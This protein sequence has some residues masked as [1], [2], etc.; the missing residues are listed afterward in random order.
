MYLTEEFQ[1]AEGF[2]PVDLAVA[3]ASSDWVSLK[4]YD[5]CTFVF[6]GAVGAAG[7]PPTLTLQQAQDVAGTGAK[8]LNFTRINVKQAAVNLQGTGQFTKVTQAAAN[9]YTSAANGDKAKLWILEI[10]AQD[11]DKINGF[12]CVRVTIADVGAT[13]QLAAALF[14]LSGSRYAQQFPPSAI[15]D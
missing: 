9:T 11:L 13:A 6:F 3:G 10:E 12:D 1:I 8:A 5:H 4:L 15:V 14:L 2:L 7:E